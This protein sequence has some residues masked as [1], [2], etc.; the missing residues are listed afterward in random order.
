MGD[1]RY[2]TVRLSRDWLQSMKEAMWQEVGRQRDDLERSRSRSARVLEGMASPALPRTPQ[3][4]QR[5]ELRVTFDPIEISREKTRP[6]AHVAV[7]SSGRTRRRRGVGLSLLDAMA[8]LAA[9]A[10][11]QARRA[12]ELRWRS[13]EER[14]NERHGGWSR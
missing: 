2:R 12:E 4:A 1:G 13:D 14:K 10:E 8:A 9:E 5:P 3:E 7:R 11:R 6:K